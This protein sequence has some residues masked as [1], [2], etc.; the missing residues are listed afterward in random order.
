M[1]NAMPPGRDGLAPSASISEIAGEAFERARIGRIAAVL[2]LWVA[3]ALVCWPS[4]EA[5]GRLW[6]N[7]AKETYTHGFLIL[8][9]SLWLTFRERDR[10]AIAPLRPVAGALIGLFILSALWTWAWRASLQELHVMLLPLIL[11]TAVLATLGPS[12]TR[13]LAF[14]IGYL[15][16]ALP[17][18]SDGNFLLQDLSARMT[19]LL[20][21]LT[22]IP[23]FMQGNFIELPFGTIRIAGG[24][25]G[26]HAFIVGL[27]LAAF[28]GRLFDLPRRRQV[29]AVALMGVLA[30]IVNW[31][32]IFI[33]T[34]AAYAT[35]MQSSLVRNH[36]WLGWWLFAAAFAGF[37]WWMERKPSGDPRPAHVAAAERSTIPRERIA[38][39][40]SEPPRAARAIATGA[41]LGLGLVF[42]VV[43]TTGLHSSLARN[44]YW[45][46]WALCAAALAGFLWWVG[47][48]HV[49]RKVLARAA[50]E[51]PAVGSQL[52]TD[53]RVTLLYQSL[54]A[55][56]VLALVPVSAYGLD[57]AHA[58]DNL[59]VR[60]L[61]PAAPADWEGPHRAYAD[62]WQPYF[63]RA[64]G[65][66]MRTYTNASG[67]T[68]QAFAVAYRVQSQQAKLLGYSN[69]LLGKS[70]SL[71]LQGQHIENAASG[72]WIEMRVTDVAGSH[73]LIWVRYQIG[74][75]S[76]VEPRLS[77]LWYGLVALIDPPLSSLTALRTACSTNCQH[78]RERLTAVASQVQPAFRSMN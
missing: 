70:G 67:Q 61:W 35:D 71:R 28:Y 45:L 18:W 33:V 73:S 20:L 65:E 59:S 26:L 32:R 27:A 23:G 57:W 31:V 50:N 22:G 58:D 68:I 55:V 6:L 2:G 9:I 44:H 30:L 17:F 21:W 42:L 60:I 1:S 34:A 16:F 48:R 13:L 49:T 38:P 15:Y 43:F 69:R 7:T 46:G 12:A 36:Y 78:A 64:G 72:Q 37:L 51:Q 52:R 10:L 41:V 62:Q 8:L 24:C 29:T 5:L 39:A 11:L 75:R 25:S 66:S 76:F 53:S 56:I 54:T 19:G 40:P 3:V 74:S 14:P 47:R 77:Q 4:S 63:V